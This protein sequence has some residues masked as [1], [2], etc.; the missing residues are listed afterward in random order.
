MSVLVG[1]NVVSELISRSP[2][3]AMGDRVAARDLEDL[4]YAAVGEAELQHCAAI[5]A[6]GRRRESLIANAERFLRETFDDRVLPFDST[7]ARA[8]AARRRSARRPIQPVD[9]QIAAIGVADGFLALIG[10]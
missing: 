4:F 10:Q 7:A 3:P 8:Y 2:D 5:L 9:C 1:T 6:P